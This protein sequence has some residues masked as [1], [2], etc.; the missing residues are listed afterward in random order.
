MADQDEKLDEDFS[1]LRSNSIAL[2]HQFYEILLCTTIFESLLF[3]GMLLLNW[4]KRSARFRGGFRIRQPF[5]V[6]DSSVLQ[7]SKA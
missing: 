3:S 4:L 5:K 1:L 7:L 6:F 2:I